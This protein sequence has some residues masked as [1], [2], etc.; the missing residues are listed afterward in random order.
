MGLNSLPGY[1]P[2]LKCKYVEFYLFP[3]NAKKKNGSEC[4]YYRVLIFLITWWG[5]VAFLIGYVC[6]YYMFHL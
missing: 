1:L 4:N 3:Q 6:K 5:N 2:K